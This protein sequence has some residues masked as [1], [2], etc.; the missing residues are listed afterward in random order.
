MESAVMRASAS[1][2]IKA[3]ADTGN[4]DALSREAVSAHFPLGRHTIIERSIFCNLQP[5]NVSF[6][7]NLSRGRRSPAR[8]WCDWHQRRWRSWRR[9][10]QP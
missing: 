10:A 2:S 3:L 7:V 1:Q 8:L 9:R 4:H 5:R 6:A